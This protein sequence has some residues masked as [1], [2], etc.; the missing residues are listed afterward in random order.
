[1]AAWRVGLT[2]PP[3][4]EWWV[5]SLMDLS[6]RG[7]LLSPLIFLDLEQSYVRLTCQRTLRRG[8]KVGM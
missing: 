3:V 6:L 2:R 7:P 1:M 5:G 8:D 4:S